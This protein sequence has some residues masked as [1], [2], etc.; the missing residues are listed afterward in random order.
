MYYS[1]DKN[2][3]HALYCISHFFSIF[4]PEITN[5]VLKCASNIS[6]VGGSIYKTVDTSMY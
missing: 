6:F 2:V 5:L 1:L 4:D 3:V